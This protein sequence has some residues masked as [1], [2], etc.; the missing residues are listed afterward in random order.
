MLL[1]VYVPFDCFLRFGAEFW[2]VDHS[3]LPDLACD[4]LQDV[5]LNNR[6]WMGIILMELKCFLLCQAVCYAL[7][8]LVF[9]LSSQ[10]PNEMPGL[11]CSIHK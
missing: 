6:V 5:R 8:T 9:S 10:E 2:I 3:V 11:P 1:N 7:Y 4:Y